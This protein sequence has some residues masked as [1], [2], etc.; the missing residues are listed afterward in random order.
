MGEYQKGI[1][2]DMEAY[3]KYIKKGFSRLH[4]R[5]DILVSFRYSDHP[6][7]HQYRRA[8]YQASRLYQN[9]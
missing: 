3:E 9:R 8:L 6:F 7:D 2:N 4:V 5:K 1:P